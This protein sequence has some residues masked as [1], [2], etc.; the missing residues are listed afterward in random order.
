MKRL[1]A[2]IE[3]TLYDYIRNKYTS[4]RNFNYEF[5]SNDKILLY[6]EQDVRD[7][8]VIDDDVG[9]FEELLNAEFSGLMS[10]EG[11]HGFLYT[12]KK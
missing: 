10:I 6:S 12:L 8:K 5:M 4:I 2:D 11:K 9:F 7:I 1:D 3:K